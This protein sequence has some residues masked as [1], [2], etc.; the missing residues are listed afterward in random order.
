L[1]LFS[2]VDSSSYSTEQ[3]LTEQLLLQDYPN[4]KGHFPNRS[5][6]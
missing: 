2:E 4:G 1:Y 5:K 3:N 6:E